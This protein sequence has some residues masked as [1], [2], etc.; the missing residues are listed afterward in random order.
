M[1]ARV[2]FVTGGAQG[3][4][5]G[6]SETLGSNGFQVAVA[7]LNL[8]AAQDTAKRIIDAGGRAFAVHVDV[9]DT[10]SVIGAVKAVVAE[11]GEIEVAVNNA[12]WD[13]F[14]PFVKTTE[15]FW[16]RILDINFKGALRVCHTVVP[17]MVERGFGRVINIGSDAG[18]VGSSLEAVYSG[19]KGG[20]IAFS[21]T[22]A[23]EVATKGITVN[24]VC[25]GP[26]DTPA[27]RKFADTSGQDADKVLG[28]M[29]KAVPMKRL[30]Q[31]S[32]IA[33]AVAFFAS[34]GAEYITGQTLSVSGGLTMA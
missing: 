29:T 25:P 31:P 32:D 27:L 34:D 8:D 21:K 14:M 11:L 6:I 33:A 20:I 16:N 15:E 19:A 24:T 3:I 5:A 12:G 7:D 1:T 13:D 22:L 10:E 17:G 26:T 4:G 28:G 9:T 30:A 2:A 23:R 18:R